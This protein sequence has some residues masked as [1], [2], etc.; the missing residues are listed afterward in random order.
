MKN[1]ICIDARYLV[2]VYKLLA[3]YTFSFTVSDIGAERVYIDFETD[4]TLNVAQFTQE[5]KDMDFLRRYD[6]FDLTVQDGNDWAFF[7]I[8]NYNAYH[9]ETVTLIDIEDI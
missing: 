7:V 2:D 5:V 9:D 6:G 3:A 1:T 8:A 4:N